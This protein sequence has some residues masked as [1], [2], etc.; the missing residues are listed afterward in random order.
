M[1]YGIL[2]TRE[3]LGLPG[4]RSSILESL[5]RRIDPALGIRLEGAAS[6]ALREL[7]RPEREAIDAYYVDGKSIAAISKTLHCT[8]NAFADLLLRTR[9]KVFGIV[10]SLPPGRPDSPN[11]KLSSAAACR[12]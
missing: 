2:P 1:D 11:E 5:K 8:E 9:R 3:S 6:S 7:A 4:Q 12:A 10:G